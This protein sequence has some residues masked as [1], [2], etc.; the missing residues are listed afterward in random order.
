MAKLLIEIFTEEIPYSL[1]KQVLE[2]LKTLF[3]SVFATYGVTDLNVNIQATP[4]RVAILIEKLPDSIPNKTTEIK[5]PSI[6]APAIALEGFL[7]TYQITKAECFVK[8]TPKGSFYFYNK[9]NQGG[10]ILKFLPQIITEVLASVSF[11]KSMAWNSSK[12]KWARPIRTLL[13]LVEKNKDCH[14]LPF[15]F[16]GLKA[17]N[18][19]STHKVLGKQNLEVNS[20]KD[21]YKILADNF[22]ILE[23][24]KRVQIITD[25]LTK[26]I[27]KNNFKPSVDSNLIEE[28]AYL[29][30]Y[31]VVLQ[32]EIPETYMGLPKEL[33][34]DI[35]VKHQ[36]YIPLFNKDGSLASNIVIVANLKAK[37]GGA[38]ILK[39]NSKVLNSR[40]SDGLFFYNNDLK[41]SL[42]NKAEKLK[43]V[44]FFEGAGSLFQKSQRVGK[45]FQTIFHEE[46]N[47]LCS[48]YKA[49]LVS[50][51]VIEIPELQGIMGYYYALNDNPKNKEIATAILEHYKP[52]NVNDSLPSTLLGA[53]LALLDKLDTLIELFALG[54]IP[55]GSKDPYA[56]RRASLGVIKIVNHFK[57][58]LDLQNILKPSLQEFILDRLEV[59][60]K[61]TGVNPD[62]VQ[63]VIK[64]QKELDT[65]NNT[66]LTKAN[67]DIKTFNLYKI[68]Q[69]IEVLSTLLKTPEGER[70]M[71]MYIRLKN[72]IASQ[73]NYQIVKVQEKLL[74]E[75]IEKKLYSS[76][77]KLI[78]IKQSKPESMVNST[79]LQKILTAIAKLQ[80]LL[81][82]FLNTIVIN[83]SPTTEMKNNRISL[84]SNLLNYIKIFI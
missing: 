61:L 53:K 13:A 18:K 63:S 65:K 59:Y 58:D 33:L 20:I 36:K 12:V 68:Y 21:Y 48:I 30:E 54:K 1:Q 28:I 80:P 73:S 66:N 16:A 25:E 26:I 27:K 38:E 47:H 37:D 78:Q 55:T 71:Q 82:E 19:I 29:V 15:T 35:I 46:Q 2:D 51:V 52:I 22:V 4:N 24:D 39:G 62:V 77:L 57:L 84:L 5:G 10:D 70:V 67:T 83:K 64:Q 81:D 40:L 79:E 11:K 6:K 3:P 41:T 72:I 49:D 31:P 60:L 50:E 43:K 17:T 7:K 45:L 42:V 76:I 23:A 56:L 8:D 34:V 69:H 32:G 75:P 9:V 14:K 74:Q 44:T